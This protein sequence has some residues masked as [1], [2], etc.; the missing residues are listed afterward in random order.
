[1]PRLSDSVLLARATEDRRLILTFD[2]DFGVLTLRGGLSAPCGI[3]LLRF[4]PQDP[5]EP[6]HLLIELFEQSGLEFASM[7]SILERERLRQRPLER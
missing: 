4:V 2:L 1:M 5:S 6:G 3:L 7:L